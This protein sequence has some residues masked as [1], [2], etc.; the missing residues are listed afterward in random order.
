IFV[1]NAFS[2]NGDGNNDYFQMFGNTAGIHSMN[3]MI[4]DRWGE[5]VFESDETDF[6]WDGVYKGAKMQPAVF[7][8]VMKV[9]FIDGR[10]SRLMKGSL[11]LVR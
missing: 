1:P 4:F 7:V 6:K 8:Y 5:K 9:T 2:P 11:T 10:D 3:I